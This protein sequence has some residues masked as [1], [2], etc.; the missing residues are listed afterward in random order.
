MLDVE[1][2][3]YRGKAVRQS[4]TTMIIMM[5]DDDDDDDDEEEEQG[6]RAQW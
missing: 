6:W 4:K 3:K 5:D 2:W 1:R